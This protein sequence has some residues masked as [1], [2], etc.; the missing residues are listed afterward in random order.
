M[1]SS[2]TLAPFYPYLFAEYRSEVNVGS[3]LW[4]C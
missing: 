2:L 1:K 4:F 3:T